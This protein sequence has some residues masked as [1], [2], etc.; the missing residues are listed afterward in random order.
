MN[1]LEGLF[2]LKNIPEAG[3]TESEVHVAINPGYPI[4][5]GHFPD[6]PILPGVCMVQIALTIASVMHAKPLRILNARTVK[7]LTPVDPRKTPDLLYHTTLSALQTGVKI[8]VNATV[9]GASVLK[10]SAELVPE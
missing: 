10:L 6:Q 4:F 1:A 9:D 8:E 7:F 2:T 5:K 3:S